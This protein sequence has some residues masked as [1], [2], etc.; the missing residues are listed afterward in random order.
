MIENVS[1]LSNLNRV[2]VPIVKVVIGDYTFGVY[3]KSTT[4]D[5]TSIVRY[6]NYVQGLTVKKINGKVNT[7]T[8]SLT[9]PINET[10][11]PNFMEKV[12]SS[13]AKTR[14]IT[15]TYGDASAPMFLYKEESAFISTIVPSF[16]IQ[17]S[18]I[19]YTIQAI[20]SGFELSSSKYSFSARDNVKASDILIELLYSDYRDLLDVFTGM[21]NKDLVLSKGLIPRDDK[22]INLQKKCNIAILDYINYVVSCM[23]PNGVDNSIQ[24]GGFYTIQVVDQ[25][26][27]FYKD[28]G[29]DLPAFTGPYFKVVEVKSQDY[30]DSMDVYSVDIGYISK[31]IVISF[32]VREQQAYSL[33]NEYQEK[34]NEDYYVHRINDNGMLEQVYAPMV[35][36]GNANFMTREEDK[37]WWTRVTEFPIE[38]T[39]TLKG[40]LKPAIL[41]NYVRLNIFFYGKK[42]IYSGLYIILGQQDEINYSG[43]RTTLQLLRVGGDKS[44]Q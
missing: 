25:S 22:P 6:P 7:Y 23:Q 26:N 1:L 16:N 40:L 14:K 17:S 31:D 37:T 34:V 20:G 10:S 44:L 27:E 3:N 41:M 36:S 13:V 33:L 38:A 35:T 43:F 2:E 24:L 28:N 39:L 9:Y 11:D 21:R 29:G 12:F 19:N 4:T 30:N 8:L 18:V 32:N 5:G 15:F 42:H